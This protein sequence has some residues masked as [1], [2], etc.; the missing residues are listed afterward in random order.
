MSALLISS[1]DFVWMNLSCSI[2]VLFDELL[3][4]FNLLL[5]LNNFLASLQKLLSPDSWLN[6]SIIFFLAPGI[7]VFLPDDL[8]TFCNISWFWPIAVTALPYSRHWLASPA[9]SLCCGDYIPAPV[10]TVGW[11]L[12]NMFG[13]NSCCSL[14]SLK[15]IRGCVFLLPSG[16]SIV[17]D[18]LLYLDSPLLK[19]SWYFPLILNICL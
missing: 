11:L 8:A 2:D 3:F 4:Y 10:L 15:S 18:I 7:P 6:L 13:E 5:L 14:S 9:L 19:T 17:L 1:L 12:L 16:K